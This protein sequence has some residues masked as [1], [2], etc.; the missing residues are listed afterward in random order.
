[1]VDYEDSDTINTF[2]E[3]YSFISNL[4]EH[5]VVKSLR[6]DW[7]RTKLDLFVRPKYARFSRIQHKQHRL[8]QRAG[9][10]S[11][12]YR[13]ETVYDFYKA[14]PRRRRRMEKLKLNF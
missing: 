3:P 14:E 4:R 11:E 7:E 12:L 1:M 8:L 10:E 6:M 13:L 2:F 9:A 5:G